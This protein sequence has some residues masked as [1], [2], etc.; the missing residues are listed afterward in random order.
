MAPRAIRRKP[1][2]GARITWESCM[3]RPITMENTCQCKSFVRRNVADA[4][5]YGYAKYMAGDCPIYSKSLPMRVSA[6]YEYETSNRNNDECGRPGP[7]WRR[8]NDS[9]ENAS[10]NRTRAG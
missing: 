5:H 2:T 9:N 6:S 7:I 1:K 4:A 10:R 8:R 3:G